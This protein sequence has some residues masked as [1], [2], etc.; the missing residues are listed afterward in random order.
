MCNLIESYASSVKSGW[1][2]VFSFVMAVR[3]FSRAS[4]EGLEPDQRL[5]QVLGIFS[6]FLGNKN[7]A[8]FASAAVQSIYTLIKFINVS[9]YEDNNDDSSRSD[10]DSTSNSSDITIVEM[11]LPALE[12]LSTMSK[13][14][15]SL[16]ILPSSLVFHGSHA[17]GLAELST[18]YVP[19]SSPTPSPRSSPVKQSGSVN[20]KAKADLQIAFKNS[21][22][23]IIKIDDTGILRV[24][25]LLLEGLTNAVAQCP[26]RFQPQTL[27]ILFD[28]LHSITTVPGPHFAIYTVTHLLLPMLQAWVERG[29]R[30]RSY[31]E[32]TAAN[33]KHACGLA[34]ELIVEELGQFLS[35]EGTAFCPFY[36]SLLERECEN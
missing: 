33:F 22:Q 16:Y 9:G 31:W 1:R 11:S 30:D 18:S 19:P 20:S 6:S 4:P 8:V 7:P 34:T 26:R 25:F 10:I 23:S 24:W 13:K 27:E 15:A 29:N 2:S 3:V 32:G 36:K 21:A 12:F 5:T 35:V 28:I 14:L 17:I